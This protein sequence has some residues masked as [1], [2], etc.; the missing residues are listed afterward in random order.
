MTWE[1]Q[2]SVAFDWLPPPWFEQS[3]EQLIQIEDFIAKDD[4]E[5]LEKYLESE[6][7]PKNILNRLINKIDEEIIKVDNKILLLIKNEL[8]DSGN[9]TID[10]IENTTL[11]ALKIGGET[12]AQQF[13]KELFKSFK[14]NPLDFKWN[15]EIDGKTVAELFM[16]SQY[17]TEKEIDELFSLVKGNSSLDVIQ[18]LDELNKVVNLRLMWNNGVDFIKTIKKTGLSAFW[19]TFSKESLIS[20]KAKENR[21]QLVKTLG[22]NSFLA[23]FLGPYKSYLN[24]YDA[25]NEVN[26]EWEE[27]PEKEKFTEI[28]NQILNDEISTWREL[29]KAW[30]N[31]NSKSKEELENKELPDIISF[32]WWENEERINLEWYNWTT[33]T[34][35][36]EKR[37][38]VPWD[39]WAKIKSIQLNTYL[40][41]VGN[42]TKLFADFPLYWETNDIEIWTFDWE[43]ISKDEFMSRID[44]YQ[45]SENEKKD[46]IEEKIRRSNNIY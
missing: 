5:W 24:M 2:Q 6:K 33:V 9:F 14:Y 4:I 46:R 3:S 40:K 8:L 21:K 31:P 29:K 12:L 25:Q 15:K 37:L 39:E 22:L 36:W 17:I 34:I 27:N 1:E 13:F 10:E 38:E 23:I 42:Q 16:D 44:E 41:K 26:A 20:N 45:T 32:N 30:I 7:I 11:V 18:K 43:K 28:W 35:F 19:D